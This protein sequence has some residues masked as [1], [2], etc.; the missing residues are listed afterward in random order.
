MLYMMAVI[1]TYT[2]TFLTGKHLTLW[3][4]HPSGSFHRH[5]Q[6]AAAAAVDSPPVVESTTTTTL[7]IEGRVQPGPAGVLTSLTVQRYGCMY[8]TCYVQM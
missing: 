8:G 2:H 4:A 6:P 1:H 3:T 5:R 7:Q